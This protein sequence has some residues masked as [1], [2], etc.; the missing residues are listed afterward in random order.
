M[1]SKSDRITALEDQLAALNKQFKLL[2]D[3]V[4]VEYVTTPFCPEMLHPVAYEHYV[5][6]DGE[7]NFVRLL[8]KTNS[9]LK[10]SV[11]HKPNISYL[12]EKIKRIHGYLG[13]KEEETQEYHDHFRKCIQFNITYDFKGESFKV[14]DTP[15]NKFNAILEKLGLRFTGIAEHTQPA[16]TIVE[17]D[18]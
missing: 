13:I 10:N 2:L 4:G 1:V 11:D 3:F 9:Q 14:V 5:T 17:H 15:K 7:N 18:F 8:E 12:D 6:S 16:K